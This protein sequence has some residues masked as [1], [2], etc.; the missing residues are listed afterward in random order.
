MICWK[1]AIVGAIGGYGQAVFVE[2]TGGNNPFDGADVGCEPKPVFVDIDHDGGDFDAFVGTMYG[3]I[4]Y[5][6]NDGTVQSPIFNEQLDASNPLTDTVA[7]LSS[8]SVN[9]RVT[10]TSGRTWTLT[11]GAD[12]A[13]RTSWNARGPAIP[14]MGWT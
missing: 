12:T 3:A 13:T 2:R 1:K 6:R 10:S 7:G 5:F 4:Q 9:S 8:S 14:S 11:T